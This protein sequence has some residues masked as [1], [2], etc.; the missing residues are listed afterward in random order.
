MRLLFLFSFVYFLISCIIFLGLMTNLWNL[1]LMSGV[2]VFACYAMLS[3]F[4]VVCSDNCKPFNQL[5]RWDS[6]VP[7]SEQILCMCVYHSYCLFWVPHLGRFYSMWGFQAKKKGRG[8]TSNRHL[9][10]KTSLTNFLVYFGMK[11]PLNLHCFVR[12][13][14]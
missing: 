6:M 8:L 7:F 14:L 2:S 12:K 5:D 1:S 3:T 10:I 11:Y 13:R 4:P 9:V